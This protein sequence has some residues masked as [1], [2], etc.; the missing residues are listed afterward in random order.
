MAP[1]VGSVRKLNRHLSIF[2]TEVHCKRVLVGGVT[3]PTKNFSCAL[4]S[5]G[6]ISNTTWYI[7]NAFGSKLPDLSYGSTNCTLVSVGHSRDLCPKTHF[8]PKNME[9]HCKRVL[10]GGVTPPAKNF[11]CALVSGGYISNASWYILN[12]F[13]GTVKKR[14]TIHPTTSGD[15]GSLARPVY[16]LRFGEQERRTFSETLETKRC[17][18]HLM[19]PRLSELNLAVNYTI[20]VMVS[21][22]LPHAGLPIRSAKAGL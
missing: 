21:W 22:H 12:A 6:Y 3:P 15:A 2:H 1:V 4:V 10:V 5:G 9:V 11:S 13:R 18:T 19:P 7:P 16:S 14:F 17:R 20:K 8:P